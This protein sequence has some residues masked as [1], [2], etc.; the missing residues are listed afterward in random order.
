MKPG[1]KLAFRRSFL[2]HRPNHM[3]RFFYGQTP[4]LGRLLSWDAISNKV[5]ALIGR[6][7]MS[8]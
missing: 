4:P 2:I 6:V 5:R 1:E 8:N 7:F 3:N